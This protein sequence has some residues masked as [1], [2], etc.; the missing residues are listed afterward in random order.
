MMTAQTVLIRLS[1]LPS[2][3]RTSPSRWSSWFVLCIALGSFGVSAL[4][5]IPPAL[6]VASQWMLVASLFVCTRALEDA[7]FWA[8]VLRIEVRDRRRVLPAVLLDGLHGDPAV[9]AVP[10]L[11]SP[12]RRC[13]CFPPP[14]RT[15]R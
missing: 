2:A 1:G 8:H 13:R 7:L 12:V 5:R 3:R 10:I 14:A 6:I 4:R 9:P 15:R 11:L